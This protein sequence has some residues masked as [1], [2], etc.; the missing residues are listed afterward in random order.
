VATRPKSSG[1]GLG[2]TIETALKEL[3]ILKGLFP[4]LPET[5]TVF[6]EWEYLVKT[7]RVSGKNTHDARLVAAMKLNGISKILTFNATDFTRYENI[8]ALHPQSV[9]P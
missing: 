4:V 1:N 9:K 8:E 6:D 2:M 3:A 7:Y 5:G